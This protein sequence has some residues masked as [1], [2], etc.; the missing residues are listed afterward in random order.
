VL[1]SPAG[2]LAGPGRLGLA[3]PKNINKNNK[4][5]K[6]YVCKKYI[7]MNFFFIH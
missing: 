2:P 3:Q 5:N 1:L 7:N 4:N 6:N